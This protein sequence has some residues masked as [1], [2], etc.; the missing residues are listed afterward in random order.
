VTLVEAVVAVVIFVLFAGA[1]LGATI[2]ATHAAASDPIRDA[3]QDEA[4]REM[5][6]ALDVLK[7]QGATLAPNAIQTTVPTAGGSPLPASVSI[8]TFE[9]PDGSLGVSVTAAAGADA[10]E[11]TTVSTSLMQRAPMPAS[12]TRVPGLAPAP[13]GAP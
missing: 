2:V 4:E 5:Y 3:L 12:Q 11:S 1:T 13:T 6:V 9:R 8:A 10:D 7:Y